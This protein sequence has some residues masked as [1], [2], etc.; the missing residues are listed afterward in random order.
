MAARWHRFTEAR[1]GN[2]GYMLSSISVNRG[3]AAALQLLAAAVVCLRLASDLCIV[4]QKNAARCRKRMRGE[5]A[6]LGCCL[7]PPGFNPV[8][9]C[10]RT[11]WC[12]TAHRIQLLRLQQLHLLHCTRCTHVVAVTKLLCAQP[13][14]M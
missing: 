8:A 1:S 13:I 11:V 12:R 9:C 4:L 3:T 10:L 5:C 6:F 2:T 7:L 14:L